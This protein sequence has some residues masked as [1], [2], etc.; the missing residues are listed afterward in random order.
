MQNF[1][2][3]GHPQII[4]DI[5]EQHRTSFLEIST[6]ARDVLAIKSQTHNKKYEKTPIRLNY[7]WKWEET[8]KFQVLVFGKYL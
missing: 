3:F 6:R 4:H 5:E 8:M 2:P 7:A 1:D